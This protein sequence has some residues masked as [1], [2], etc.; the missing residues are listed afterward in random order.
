M[1]TQLFA[2]WIA[3]GGGGWLIGVTK[4]RPVW[5]FLIGFGLGFI[6]MIIMLVM[7]SK[8]PKT[9]KLVMRPG[10]RR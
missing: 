10:V 6:G 7:P 2:L 9:P 5:G 3:L 1:T 8:T 4:G